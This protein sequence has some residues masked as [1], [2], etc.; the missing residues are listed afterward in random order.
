MDGRRGV[1][2]KDSQTY[3][4][5]KTNREEGRS[6]KTNSLNEFTLANEERCSLSVIIFLIIKS[7]YHRNP[8]CFFYLVVN[9]PFMELREVKETLF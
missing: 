6:D 4:P 3:K 8:Y 7:A 9:L 2:K 5:V 1:K